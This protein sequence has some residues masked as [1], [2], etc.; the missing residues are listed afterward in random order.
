MSAISFYDTGAWRRKRREVLRACNNECQIC[1]A[2]HIHTRAEIVHHVFHL[3]DYPQWGLLE[4]V[5]DPVTGELT[6]NLLPVCRRCHE[7]VCHPG[8]LRSV[9]TAAPPL[10]VERW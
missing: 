6:R 7:T 2:R 10:T 4:F 8:R 3:E 9:E 1:K 5:R